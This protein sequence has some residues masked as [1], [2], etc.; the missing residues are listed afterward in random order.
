[1]QKEACYY[2]FIISNCR[3]LIQLMGSFQ[4]RRVRPK[5]IPFDYPIEWLGQGKAVFV[6]YRQNTC[7]C[8]EINTSFSHVHRNRFTV[9]CTEPYFLTFTAK[10]IFKN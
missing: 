4:N 10:K 7:C 3:G 1:M 5:A 9:F 2:F 8:R 6:V